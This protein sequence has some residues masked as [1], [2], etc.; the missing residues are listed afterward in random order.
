MQE[1]SVLWIDGKEWNMCLMA[2]ITAVVF[3][4]K[5]NRTPNSL[6]MRSGP[7][8]SSSFSNTPLYLAEESKTTLIGLAS[9]GGK[10]QSVEGTTPDWTGA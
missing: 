5:G 6:F 4:L 7:N 1:V 8:N 2:H 10:L 3:L 9:F